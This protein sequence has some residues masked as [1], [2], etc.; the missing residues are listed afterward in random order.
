MRFHN[1]TAGG[2]RPK[3]ALSAGRSPR[4]EV[5]LERNGTL[6]FAR[7]PSGLFSASSAG[8]SVAS[9]GYANVWVRDNVYVAF[10]HQVSG[11]DA[12]R[13]GRRACP[14]HVLQPPPPQVRSDNRRR[15]PTR[16]M[17]P[18]GLTF[19]SMG[20]AWRRFRTSAG[21]TRRTMRSDTSCGSTPGSPGIGT[22]RWMNW[23]SPRWRC[24]RRISRHP[25]LAGSGQRTLGGGAENLGLEHRHRRGGTRGAA[26]CRRGAAGCV[27][28]RAV[29][30]ETGGVDR[31]SIARGRTALDDILPHE[32]A[33]L[34][35]GQNRRY[36]AALLFLLFPLDVI[37]EPAVGGA[38]APRR[39]RF[40]KGEV[41]IRRYLGDSYWAPDYEDRLGPE[42]RTRDFSDD[43][44]HG[45]CCSSGSATKRSGAC[46]IRFCPPITGGATWQRVALGHRAADTPLQPDARADYGIMALPRTVLPQGRRLRPEPATAAA[47]DPG[48]SHGRP[49]GNAG[50]D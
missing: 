40:L 13:G 32:C 30:T 15:R 1:S 3:R 36:D 43:M 5:E 8:E 48:E 9:S 16:R 10:A 49:A 2:P 39:E 14:G 45:T 34:S 27:S 4:I 29:R 6:T 22:S 20:T 12:G 37:K 33:Q 50:H 23:P 42:D 21:R 7:L 26:P 28:A 18:S 19:V 24:F 38:P 11:P 41:G 44:A 17:C 46:S 47:V 35:P 25:I 31:R